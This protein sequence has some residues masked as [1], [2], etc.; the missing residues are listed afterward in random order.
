MPVF[1]GFLEIIRVVEDN[2]SK[3]ARNHANHCDIKFVQHTLRQLT[4]NLPRWR[5]IWNIVMSINQEI[6]LIWH[7]SIFLPQVFISNHRCITPAGFIYIKQCVHHTV[8]II[9]LTVVIYFSDHHWIFYVDQSWS[10]S[11]VSIQLKLNGRHLH[12]SS[13]PKCCVLLS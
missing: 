6:L 9:F 5:S 1:P 10:T 8:V 7:S 11:S 4:E 3:V 12:T 13:P 2:S